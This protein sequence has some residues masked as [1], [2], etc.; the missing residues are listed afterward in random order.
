MS[1]LF[2][3]VWTPDPSFPVSMEPLFSASDSRVSGAPSSDPFNHYR[4]GLNPQ[5]KFTK[6]LLMCTQDLESSLPRMEKE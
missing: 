4:N 6:V 5:L 3:W 2:S 1:T